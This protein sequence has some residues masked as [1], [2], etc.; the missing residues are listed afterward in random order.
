MPARAAAE[1][2]C[3]ERCACRC[4]PITWAARSVFW[5]NVQDWIRLSEITGYS[6][7]GAVAAPSVWDNG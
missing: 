2:S 3:D 6:V 7:V 4:E 1:W 5:G